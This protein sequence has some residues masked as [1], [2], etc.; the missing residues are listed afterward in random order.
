[1]S[2][3]DNLTGSNRNTRVLV[4]IA[5]YGEKNIRYLK[6][7]IGE[8]RRMAMNVDLAVFSNAPK[9]LE[10]C[11]VIV[12]LPSKNPWSL[13]FA[14]K[15]FFAS[16]LDRYDLFIYSEDD[17][18]VTEGNIQAF[19]RVSSHLKP[20]EIAGFLRYEVDPTGARSLP[21][22]HGPFH[23]KPQSV[24]RRERFT[25]A[26]FSNEHAG[27]YILTQGQL[28]QAIGSGGFLRTPCEGRYGMLET[29]ATDPYTNCGFCK[30]IPISTVEDFL[31]HHMPNR[32][33]GQF[34]ISLRA[35]QEQV[36]TLL[37][38]RDGLH[39]ASILCEVESKMPRGKFSKTYFEE[40]SVELL[41]M[42]PQDANT[43]LSI[44]C[45]AGVMELELARRGASIT[46]LPLDSVVGVSGE[47]LGF[48]VIYGSMDECFDRLGKRKFGCVLIPNL[49][50]LQS[51][52]RRLLEQ[53]CRFVEAGGTLILSGPNFYSIPM[54]LKHV[55]RDRSYR[56]LQ[57][58]STS[59]I[60]VCGTR[61]LTVCLRRLGLETSAIRWYDR[62]ADRTFLRRFALRFGGVS[63]SEWIIQAHRFASSNGS[64]KGELVN[65][66]N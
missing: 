46:A 23:W 30:V 22:V 28:R 45:G 37:Q 62:G 44:G 3:M 57:N 6:A 52:P 40:P 20:T 13:P 61:E 65:G 17:I 60:H 4:A 14:H 8:Y 12:G 49:I 59:G 1:M 63:A 66:Q 42:V 19:L 43:I 9:D 29:A 26:E 56:R 47:R 35:F 58:F 18:G 11:K 31:I 16:N 7:I 64:L 51:D 10:D 38:I 53:A 34:G 27:F 33:I 15:G 36:R 24:R 54:L 48:E 2:A 21:D 32:Y 55:V 5:S 39:P 50:H 41:E 25:I